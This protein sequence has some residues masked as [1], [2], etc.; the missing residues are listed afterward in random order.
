MSGRGTSNQLSISDPVIGM[1]ALYVAMQHRSLPPCLY[2]L[3][4][5]RRA[6]RGGV[7]IRG[8]PPSCAGDRAFR[9]GTKMGVTRRCFRISLEYRA[10]LVWVGGTSL[11]QTVGLSLGFASVPGQS[12]GFQPLCGPFRA[13]VVGR[14]A[15]SPVASGR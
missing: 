4:D 1:G 12:P 3:Q 15:Q 7:F 13:A 2:Q 9:M 11:Q 5:G 14:D 6:A 10:N 8:R